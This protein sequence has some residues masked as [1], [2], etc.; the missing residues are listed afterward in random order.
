MVAG[1]SDFWAHAT[2]GK[3]SDQI[4][5]ILLEEIQ[6]GVSSRARN[7]VDYFDGLVSTRICSSEVFDI[8]T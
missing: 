5:G 3:T 4:L 7:K 2:D 8:Y 1:G 6:E